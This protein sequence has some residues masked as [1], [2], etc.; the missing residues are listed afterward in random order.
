MFDKHEQM[1]LRRNLKLPISNSSMMSNFDIVM[2]ITFSK[3][4]VVLERN[5]Y[6][7][8]IVINFDSVIVINLAKLHANKQLGN[9]N[10]FLFRSH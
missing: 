5:I 3:L 10:C 7:S 4:D 9:S 1:K 8:V 2:K 6:D